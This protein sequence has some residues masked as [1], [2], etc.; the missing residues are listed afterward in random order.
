MQTHAVAVAGQRQRLASLNDKTPR[1][2]AQQQAR[3]AGAES[4]LSG[5]IAEE[6]VSYLTGGALNRFALA[7][8]SGLDNEIDWACARLVAATHQAPDSWSVKAHA[9]FLVE[10]VLAELGRARAELTGGGRGVGNSVDLIGVALGDAGRAAGARRAGE[11][12]GLLATAL[13]NMAQVGDNAAAL[14]QDLRVTAEAAAWLRAAADG[15]GAAV[16]VAADLLDLLD[17][18]VPLAP[19]PAFDSAAVRAWPALG[20]RVASGV[21]AQALVETC[22]WEQ[23]VRVACAS[24]ERALVVGA[25]RVLVQSVAWHPQL[26]RDVLALRVPPWHVGGAALGSVGELVALRLAELVLAPDAELVSASLELLLNLVRLEAMARALDDE[27]DAFAARGGGIPPRRRRQTQGDAPCSMLPA[28]LAALVALVLQQWMAA[29]CPPAA[30]ASSQPLA[31]PALAARAGGLGAREPPAA[32]R[33]PTEPEL[34]EACTWVLLNYEY[35]APTASHQPP[36]VAVADIFGRYMAAK[37]AQTAPRIGRALTVG[38]I[39]RVVAAVFPRAA[40]AGGGGGVAQHVQP[41]SPSI[42]PIPAVA[43]AHP[44]PDAPPAAR[45]Q[46]L[47]CGAGFGAADEDAAAAHV[48]AHAAGADACRWRSCNRAVPAAGLRRHVLAHGPFCGAASTPPVA[49]QDASSPDVFEA[50][51]ALRDETARA[52]RS[53]WP[54]V[55]GA[56]PEHVQRVVLQGMGVI[57][58]LQRW[59]DRRE[60]A[61]GERDRQ[62]VWRG[63]D[64]VLERVAHVAAQPAA[65]S[66]YAA[67]LLAV[68][69]RGCVL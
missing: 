2:Q 18:I 67:R 25:L 29:A 1:Q 62:R 65:I 5:F 35:V 27:L 30:H 52:L 4:A 17:V 3:P 11:R 69:S 12:A 26:A 53:V 57:E 22:V 43:V 61:H 59:A 49:Q 9:P 20:A 50:A 38:E 7:L 64:A 32:S 51:R 54:L 60:G 8:K 23:A 44:P 46:W 31:N 21:D 28:G 56:E 19:A 47:G 36:A 68:L 45:C 15:A 66:H 63:A 37:Q 34:R 55:G 39:V 41:K 6:F 10:A 58:Q 13:F 48:A 33:P 40:L 16:A 24:P 42:V 14:A